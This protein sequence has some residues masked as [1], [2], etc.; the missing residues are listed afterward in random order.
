M[1]SGPPVFS[2]RMAFITS[3]CL[4]CRR[5]L[6][7][8]RLRATRFPHPFYHPERHGLS[9]QRGGRR[10]HGAADL[11]RV[12]VDPVLQRQ[13]ALHQSQ[14]GG[15]GLSAGRRAGGA[16]RATR[17][18]AGP[19]PLYR[20]PRP[21][22]LARRLRRRAQARLWRRCGRAGRRDH[23]GLQPGLL[24]RHGGDRQAGRQRDPAAA[25]FLQSPHV[26]G[27]AGHRAAA[28]RKRSGVQA[29]RSVP[30]PSSTSAPAPSC[31]CRR[32][33]RP[34]SCARRTPYW[35]STRWPSA[36]ASRW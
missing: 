30:R 3:P 28:V 35:R 32:T 5:S 33:I 21:A 13:G 11:R 2:M 31:W 15:A 6:A 36:A 18:R 26:A 17:P 20:H 29:M 16:H 10:D 9:D 8:V 12:L 23:G 4:S 25:L 1:T 34:A 19:S 24:P 22:E 27:H 7:P 14:P